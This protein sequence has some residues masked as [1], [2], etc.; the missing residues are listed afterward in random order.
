[1]VICADD[2][3]LL[4]KL[5]QAAEKGEAR[6]VTQMKNIILGFTLGSS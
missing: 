4:D 1:M 5:D 2:P 6:E 3:D